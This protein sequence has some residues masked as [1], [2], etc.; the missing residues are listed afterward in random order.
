MKVVSAAKKKGEKHAYYRPAF[1]KK[2]V[3]VGVKPKKIVAY[4][5]SRK[6]FRLDPAGYF[7]LKVFYTKH[8][9][10]ARF[11]NNDHVPKYD[12]VGKHAEEIYATIVRTKITNDAMHLAYIGHELHKAEVAMK[13]HLN[14]VQDSPLD[15]S[16]KTKKKESNN[17][18]E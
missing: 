4:H 18:P 7:I 6:E 2:A 15:Y 3:G 13:L 1:V 8:Q 17:L 10:G 14:F 9:I 5:D 16:M 12:F 11:C